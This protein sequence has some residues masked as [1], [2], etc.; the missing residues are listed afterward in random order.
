MLLGVQSRVKNVVWLSYELF[1]LDFC[2]Q[3]IP[4]FPFS[5]TQNFGKFRRH[6]GMLQR[7]FFRAAVLSGVLAGGIMAL[8]LVFSS[9]ASIAA[10]IA[11]SRCA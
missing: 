7:L 8:V 11:S 6:V 3:F 2:L 4:Q 10:S 9:R 5:R 1:C